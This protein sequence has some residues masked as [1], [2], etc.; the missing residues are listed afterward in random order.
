MADES[1][2][3]YVAIGDSQTEGLWDGDDAT[4]LRGFADRLAE[5]LE[6]S[7]PGVQY[8]N[9]AVRGRRIRDVL[10]NQLPRALT[11]RPDLITSCIGMND[12]T[13]PGKTFATALEDIDLLHDRLAETGAT[14]VTTTFPDLEQI[15]PVGR[16]LGARVLQINA[17]I[18]A[19][20]ARHGFRLVDLYEAPSLSDPDIWSPDRVHGSPA[21][22]AVFADAAAEALNLPGSSHDWAI[23]KADVVRPGLRSRMYSQALWTQN[24]LMPWIWRHLRGLSSGSGR[25]PKRPNLMPVA[26]RLVG[27]AAETAE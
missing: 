19:A 15:L 2:L 27:E 25:D 10:D 6:E 7:N 9:L 18:R 20:A 16:F 5:R 23:L 26:S 22:H 3:R 14:I 11:M 13:R 12:V 4:G 1:Y 24:L 17:V 8:A 21:G